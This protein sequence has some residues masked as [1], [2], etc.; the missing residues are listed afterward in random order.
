M[1]Q[2]PVTYYDLLEKA[3][4]DETNDRKVNDSSSSPQRWL[5]SQ[6]NDTDYTSVSRKPFSS[7]FDSPDIAISGIERLVVN[8]NAEREEE[9]K[10]ELVKHLANELENALSL[11]DLNINI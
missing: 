3:L 10:K 9:S 11:F 5:F 1:K 2:S 4:S 7:S 8:R 6:D